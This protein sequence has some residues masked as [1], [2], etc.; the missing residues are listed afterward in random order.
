MAFYSLRYRKQY[1]SSRNLLC[2]KHFLSELSEDRDSRVISSNSSFM[3]WS[4]TDLNQSQAGSFLNPFRADLTPTT[5]NPQTAPRNCLSLNSHGRYSLQNIPFC[6][7][8]QASLENLTTLKDCRIEASEQK[9]K[10]SFSDNDQFHVHSVDIHRRS[11]M[12]LLAIC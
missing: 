6:L 4:I 11:L 1:L 12:S 5:E 10:S 2:G 8:N 9:L 3:R 7:Q